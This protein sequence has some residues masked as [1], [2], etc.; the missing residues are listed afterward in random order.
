CSSPPRAAPVGTNRLRPKRKNRSGRIP[1]RSGTVRRTGCPSGSSSARGGDE[2]R[3]RPDGPTGPRVP[4]DPSR[5]HET[6]GLG[7]TSAIGGGRAPGSPSRGTGPVGGPWSLRT[8][9]AYPFVFED[10][11]TEADSLP[12][13]GVRVRLKYGMTLWPPL[14]GPPAEQGAR[15]PFRAVGN[16]T[17]WGLSRRGLD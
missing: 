10:P 1:C 13:P 12:H 4:S 7:R 8:S 14:L 17:P 2:S 11:G 15:G 16:G 3:G 6:R 5:G 9:A